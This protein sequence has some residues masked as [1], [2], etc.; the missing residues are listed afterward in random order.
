MSTSMVQIETFSR[1]YRKKCEKISK[2]KIKS[3]RKSRPG[4][5][6]KQSR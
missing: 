5:L 2:M 3:L 1:L 4:K 6:K